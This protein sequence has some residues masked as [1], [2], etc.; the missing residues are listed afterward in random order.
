MYSMKPLL[1]KLNALAKN[2]LILIQPHVLLSFLIQ[3]FAF[4]SNFLS[5]T[6]WVARQPIKGVYKDAFSLFR[7]YDHRYDLYNYVIESEHLQNA[8]IVYMEMGVCGGSSFQWWMEHNHNPQSRFYG[9]DTFEGLPEKWGYFFKNGDMNSAAPELMDQRGKFLKGLFQDT[10][11]PFLSN[12]TIKGK[13]KVIHLDADLFSSTLFS[14]S[15]LYPYLQ[16]GDILFFDE[17]NVPNH[18]FLAFKIFTETFYVPLELLGSVNN[19]YQAS[20]MVK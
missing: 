16:K 15:T 5:L 11:V 17:F 8:E 18:E 6:K 19:F 4:F 20:F 3:P 7:N 12:H 14:L 2:L 10:L 1:F 13:R 9:F